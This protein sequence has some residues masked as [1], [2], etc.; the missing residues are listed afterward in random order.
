[1]YYILDTIPLNLQSQLQ[2]NNVAVFPWVLSYNKV[3]GFQR[4][5]VLL[6][7]SRKFLIEQE[8][9]GKVLEIPRYYILL[10]NFNLISGSISRML[11]FNMLEEVNGFRC[12]FI[13]I[14]VQACMI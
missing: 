2:D 13:S 12:L 5:T 6:T 10:H 8:H 4:G 7:H 14:S 11:C 9:Y 1:M 3:T